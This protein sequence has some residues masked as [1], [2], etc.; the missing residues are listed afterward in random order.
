MKWIKI[1]EELP[2]AGEYILAFDKT[3]KDKISIR[4]VF[5]NINEQVNNPSS[6]SFGISHWMYLPKQPKN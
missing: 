1:K 5:H 6:K 2:K 4:Y 3:K